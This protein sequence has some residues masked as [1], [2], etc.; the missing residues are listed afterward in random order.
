MMQG[1]TQVQGDTQADTGGYAR[2]SVAQVIHSAYAWAHGEMPEGQLLPLG[3]YPRRSDVEGDTLLEFILSECMVDDV[4][5]I[6]Q[7]SVNHWMLARG[8]ME[9]VLEEV[10]TIFRA[11]HN[12]GPVGNELDE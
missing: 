12:N 11:L 7:D 5:D 4:L 8:R 1:D 3:S 9:T 6:S 10:Q 2:A